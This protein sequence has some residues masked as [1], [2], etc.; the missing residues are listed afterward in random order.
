LGGQDPQAAEAVLV[1]A[2]DGARNETHRFLAEHMLRR[3]G[4]ATAGTAETRGRL[5]ALDCRPGGALDFVVEAVPGVVSGG[6]ELV[7]RGRTS[8][9]VSAASRPLRLRASSPSSVLLQDG[10][11][12]QLQRELVCGPQQGAVRVRYRPLTDPPTEGPHVDGVLLTMRFVS[13]S[14]GRPR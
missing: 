1:R 8:A 12:E 13:S 3:L 14:G 5:L 6:L 7:M 4:E 2:R 10:A 9:P 11:G